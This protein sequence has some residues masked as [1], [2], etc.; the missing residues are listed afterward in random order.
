MTSS[1]IKTLFANIPAK[2]I[3]AIAKRYQP[4]IISGDIKVEIKPDGTKVT[5][6]DFEIQKLL[7]DYFRSS[8]LS[9]YFTVQGEETMTSEKQ[10]NK[11]FKIIIDPL[12]GTSSFAKGL[13][14]WGTMIGLCDTRQLIYSWCVISTGEIFSSENPKKIPLKSWKEIRKNGG[15]PT[16]DVYDYKKEN[17]ARD[18]FPAVFKTTA[19]P[20]AIWAAWELFNGRLDGLIWLPSDEGKKNYPDYDLVFLDALKRQG[21]KILLGKMIVIAPTPEDAQELWNIGITLIG[22]KQYDDVSN[23]TIS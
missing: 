5:P 8:P 21:W 14:T 4:K 7:I 13:A 19:Y 20:A 12:D 11:P 10:I 9:Q 15:Q 18:K 6:A 16:V 17:G 3:L 22:D 1:K 23:L 2:E